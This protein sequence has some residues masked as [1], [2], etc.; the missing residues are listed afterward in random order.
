MPPTSRHEVDVTLIARSLLLSAFYGIILVF[1]CILFLVIR[2]EHDRPHIYCEKAAWNR[3][4]N[5]PQSPQSPQSGSG[6]R[7]D[8]RFGELN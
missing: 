5:K 3:Q 7:E 1:L 6:K 8:L 2:V 4:D